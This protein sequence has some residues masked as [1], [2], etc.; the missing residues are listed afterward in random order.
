MVI[1]LFLLLIESSFFSRFYCIL[2]EVHFLYIVAGGPYGGPAGNESE[3]SG[4]PAG[5]NTY[6]DGYGIPQSQV[7]QIPH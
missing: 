7:S 1:L 6:E 4:H 3:A 5:K 2:Y